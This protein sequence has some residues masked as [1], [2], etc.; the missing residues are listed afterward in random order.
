MSIS[1]FHSLRE[2]TNGMPLEQQGAPDARRSP[3]L[4]RLSTQVHGLIELTGTNMSIECLQDCLLVCLRQVERS[5]C[6]H[7]PW[8]RPHPTR[9][10]EGML[11]RTASSGVKPLP[12]LASLLAASGSS[13]LTNPTPIRPVLFP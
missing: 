8:P 7:R 6:Y 4:L 11:K 3:W 5:V 13:S 12:S 2:L 9:E 10:A 1:T